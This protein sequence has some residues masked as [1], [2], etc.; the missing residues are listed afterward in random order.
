MSLTEEM[1]ITGCNKDKN[2]RLQT[3]S[4]TDARFDGERELEMKCAAVVWW[5]LLWTVYPKVPGSSSEWEPIFYEARSAAQG[6][7][8]PSSLQ[9]ST[10]GTS[11]VEHQNGDWV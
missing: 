8:E 5:L 3:N 4:S 9:G 7:P 11:P 10:L 6:L 2:V 1:C